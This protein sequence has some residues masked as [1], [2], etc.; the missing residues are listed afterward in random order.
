M[1]DS[2]PPLTTTKGGWRRWLMFAGIGVASC[3]VLSLLIGAFAPKTTSTSALNATQI[4]ETTAISTVVS[5]TAVPATAI[6]TTVL[7]TE[8]PTAIPATAIP[9]VV[10]ATEIP[11]EI[12]ATAIPT[13][14]PEPVVLQGKGDSI[15]DLNNPFG[16][17]LYQISGNNCSGYFGVTSL[18]SDGQQVDLVVNTTEVYNGVRPLD[19]GEKKTT[20][21]EI[22]ATCAWKITILPLTAMHVLTVPGQLSGTGD[23]VVMVRGAKA[24]IA[25]V[26]G[27]K[28]SRYFGVFSYGQ[29]GYDVL[30]NSTDV[31]DGKVIIPEG[32]L[33]LEIKSVGD[34]NI[35]ISAK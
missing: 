14:A 34:W 13:L 24:D 20:R 28:S 16:A 11:T 35:A 8:V 3:C 32:T 33:A 21:L 29:S 6:P 1:Q 4:V 31:Y 22:K 23:D 26:T 17:A 30:V 2:N 7:A 25:Q 5:A 19:F 27:N 10:P 12:P 9:T 15:E 18:D